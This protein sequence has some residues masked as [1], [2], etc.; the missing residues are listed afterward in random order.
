MNTKKLHVLL[1]LIVLGLVSCKKKY[2]QEDLDT[3]YD[4]GV[5]DGIEIGFD[6]GYAAGHADGYEEARILFQTEDYTNGFNDGQ[7]QGYT[8]G[9][10]AGQTQGYNTGFTAGYNS[11][12]NQ[13]ETEIYNQGYADGFSA[14]ESSG[15]GMG[16]EDGFVDGDDHGYDQGYLDGLA[17]NGAYNQGYNHGYEDGSDDGFVDGYYVG[18]YDGEDDGYTIGYYDGEEDGYSL[19]YGDGYSDGD[20]DGF[21]DGYSA[22]VDDGYYLGFDDGYDIGYGDGYGDGYDDGYYDGGWLSKSSTSV[23][24]ANTFINDLVDF[25]KIKAIKIS[26]SATL[27]SA[28]SSR[29]LE[30]MQAMVEMNKLRQISN[31]LVVKF[32]LSHERSLQL[33]KLSSQWQKISTSRELTH[34]DVD[35]FSQKIMASNLKDVESALKQSQKG[36]VAPLK[37]ILEKASAV[38]QIDPEHASKIIAQLFF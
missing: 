25:T 21:N 31:Q 5:E 9:F 4:Q 36:D 8:L 19:G 12:Y 32:A 2:T 13:A 38:N 15:Y 7:A 16:Y 6:Q 23:K 29:D 17:D 1:M 24:L 14:G 11:G 30:K 18:Y 37:E 33:A 26:R 34:R 28:G 27:S 20:W 10:D 35:A 22:G 3:S